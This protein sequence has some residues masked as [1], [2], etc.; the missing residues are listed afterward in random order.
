MTYHRYFSLFTCS[1]WRKPRVQLFC[2]V[3]L[4]PRSKVMPANQWTFLAGIQAAVET[5]KAVTIQMDIVFSFRTG[6]FASRLYGATTGILGDT[7][8]ATKDDGCCE[9]YTSNT[10][11]PGVRSPL[12]LTLYDCAFYLL[13]ISMEL[14]SRYHSGILSFEWVL[15]FAPRDYTLYTRTFSRRGFTLDFF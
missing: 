1:S 7:S 10:Q 13:V 2:M 4:H 15:H 9:F 14:A 3:R 12:Q 11:I 6:K 5:V 8:L